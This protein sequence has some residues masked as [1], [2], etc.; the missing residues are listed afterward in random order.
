MLRLFYLIITTK[1]Q[2]FYNKVA[3][4]LSEVEEGYKSADVGSDHYLVC[5]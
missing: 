1:I 2:L 3:Q 4:E 5:S